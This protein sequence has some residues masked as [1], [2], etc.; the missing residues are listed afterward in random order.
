MNFFGSLRTTSFT[1]ARSCRRYA[2]QLG[3]P[4]PSRLGA[5]LVGWKA[6]A[7]E[8]SFYTTTVTE[9]APSPPLRYPRW[10]NNAK[11]KPGSSNGQQSATATVA[12]AEGS[13]VVRL[14][15]PRDNQ[16]P[17]ESAP[18]AAPPS[19]S[20]AGSGSD[21][22]SGS[23]SDGSDPPSPPPPDPPAQP[24]TSISKQSV[25][26]VYPQVLALPIARRP[27]F[28]GFY[29]AV[30]IRNPAVV[31]AI[32]EMMRRG[33]PYLGA[34]LLKDE[35]TDSDV[36]TD[37]NSVHPVG[38][39]AQITSVFT[40]SGKDDDKEEGLTAVLYPHRRIKITELVKGGNVTVEPTEESLPSPPPEPIAQGTPIHSLWYAMW[41][42][43]HDHSPR[44]DL[45]PAGLL[46]LSSEC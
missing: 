33:Q 5:Q 19:S 21:S 17:P 27:L 11:L 40:A 36:I 45:I 41:Y 30:V 1:S 9:G 37:V 15:D 38:V 23:G 7:H 35:H 44:T 4:G 31:A 8:R 46:Y 6:R 12:E 26:E 29:K 16:T 14:D 28:P 34:F 39:F 24:Q 20:S 18:P 10:V 32:K 22:G 2:V 3:E 25:P 42:S 43:S 13:E